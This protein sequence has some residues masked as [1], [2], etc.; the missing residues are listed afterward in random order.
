MINRKEEPAISLPRE[1]NIQAAEKMMS[2]QGIPV[3]IIKSGTQDLVKIEFVFAAGNIAAEFPLLALATNDLLDEGTAKHDSAA[4]AE[5]LDF[6]GAYL[7]TDN[8]ADW[9]S[10]SLF[11]L[12]KFTPHTLPYL[13][14]LITTPLFP[15]HEIETYKHQ[16]KQHLAVN[17]NKVDFLARRNFFNTLYGNEHPYGKLVEEV[18]Y[19]RISSGVLGAYHQDRYL[20]G[21]KAVFLSGMP[22]QQ[23]I[24]NILSAIDSNGFRYGG[25][26]EI[27][28][29]LPPSTKKF[30]KKEDALQSAIRIGR[31]LFNRKHPDYFSFHVL[32]TVLGGYFGSRLMANIREDKGYTYG[33]GA[34]LISHALDGY[35]YISTEVGAE[36]REDAVREIYK[37]IARL[38][39]EEISTEELDLVKN[40]LTGAFQRSID[41]AF[42]LA[43]RH[44]M[45]VLNN[46]DN[47]YLEQYLTRLT[48]VTAGDLFVC[49]QKYLQ[50]D[51]LSE[52]VVGQ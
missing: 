4:L 1:I 37:E 11:S 30:I 25:L 5:A 26:P 31:R 18:Q 47:N 17:L 9:S 32:S 22:D 38:R 49:A 20:R 7:Q 19:D 24:D 29:S 6:Y 51:D 34:G 10:V 28:A 13:M 16:G 35:F 14:E 15:E 8:G 43:D 50:E 23:T 3:Y 52:I 39:D 33:I 36:V 12:N 46:L 27:K 40:Y 45:I 44:K 48:S 21:L 41:G 42:P 2:G